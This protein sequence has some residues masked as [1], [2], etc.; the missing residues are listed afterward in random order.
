MSEQPL[1]LGQSG[2]AERRVTDQDRNNA[3]RFISFPFKGQ[4][5]T[6][7]PNRIFSRAGILLN[8]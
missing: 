2:I 8:F 1:K 3:Q 6:F 4:V 7:D 5:Y